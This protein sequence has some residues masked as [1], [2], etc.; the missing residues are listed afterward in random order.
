M[1]PTPHRF[2]GT[3]DFAPQDQKRPDEW[4]LEQ[5]FGFV[6]SDGL[7]V[8][9]LAGGHT[10]GA[11]I[12][13]LMWRVVGHPFCRANRFWG[14]IHDGGYGG[15]AVIINT[16]FAPMPPDEL[17]TKWDR[18]EIAPCMIRSATLDRKWW[19]ET[20]VEAMCACGEPTWK[21]EAVYWGVRAFGWRA[22]RK[23]LVTVG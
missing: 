14:L 5:P 12:P 6:R 9:A 13:R 11:S 16:L 23:R 15:Y 22:Y 18:P 1:T 19:D 4:R 17:L 10:D 2:V 8:V 21:R 7:M 3:L 20:M